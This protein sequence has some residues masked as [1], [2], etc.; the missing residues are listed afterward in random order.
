MLILKGTYLNSDKSAYSIVN[1]SN[2]RQ[3]YAR[4]LADLK[5]APIRKGWIV[6]MQIL[7]TGII[8]H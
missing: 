4:Y 7:I 3:Y 1:W 6:Q 5:Q 8:E 2:F